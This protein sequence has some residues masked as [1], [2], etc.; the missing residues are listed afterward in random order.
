MHMAD[1]L[2]STPVGVGLWV[3][4]VTTSSWA[5][6]RLQH[7]SR[8]HLVPL[9]GVLGAFVF[10]AQMLNFA[11]P[12]TGSSGHL[13]GGLL[14]ASLLGGPAAFLVMASVLLVQALLFADGGL[15]AWGANVFNLGVWPCLVLYPLVLRPLLAR[16]WRNPARRQWTTL[17]SVAVMLTALVALQ[18]GAVGVVLE[19]T[20]S[21]VSSL[22]TRGFLGLMLPIHLAIGLV[23]GLATAAVLAFLARVRPDLLEWCDTGIDADHQGYSPRRAIVVWAVVATLL[24]VVAT[25]LASPLPDGLEWSIARLNGPVRHGVQ[26]TL[27]AENS[28]ASVMGGLVTLVL[29]VGLA[30][31]F[32]RRN[33][34]RR[35]QRPFP[36]DQA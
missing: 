27:D 5:G 8:S 16:R 13:G 21:D 9:M 11:I 14:L 18:L 2:L 32:R 36:A 4:T 23:E 1:A 19:T 24:A 28:W 35:Q 26:A 15:L 22:P 34:T 12:G 30:R 3:V 7:D 17:Q 25:W 31:L 10:A 33:A 6:R 20:F 29:I